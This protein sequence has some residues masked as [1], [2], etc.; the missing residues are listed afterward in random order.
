MND[1]A[2]RIEELRKYNILDTLTEKDY[3]DATF[4]ASV[5]CDAPIALISFV[6]EERQWFKSHR[7]LSVSE[8]LREY[9]FCAHAIA[10]PEEIMI[11]EDSRIDERFKNNPLVT[12]DPKIVFYAGVPLINEEGFGLGTVC[13]ID[14]KVRTLSDDQIKALKALS[15]QVMNLLK[16]RKINFELEKLKLQL[17]TRNKDLEQF[18]MVVSHDI[19]SPLTTILLVNDII[20]QNF[21]DKSG[22]QFNN[23]ISRSNNSANKI[24]SLVDGILAYYQ[25]N[26]S[27]ISPEKIDINAFFESLNNTITS[28][29]KYIITH[30][31]D[32]DVLFFSKVQLEQIFYN[33]VNN[34]IRYNDKEIVQ[35]NIALSEDDNF[36]KFSF[37][38]NGIGIARENHEKI[39][40]LFTT[41]S[42]A[43]N[44]GLRGSGIGLSTIKKIIENAKGSIAVSSELGLGT[45]FKFTIKKIRN[46]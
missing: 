30:T 41:L 19:K 4:L 27:F 25:D 5:I 1:E 20:K 8:T 12:G 6:D 45:T 42:E 18:A 11:V 38:D 39:F 32:I 33:L 22:E 35:I 40:D 3:E 15:T 14:S 34:S 23:L 7:G 26:D 21:T 28:A 44:L 17:E 9:S 37:T 43:D 31:N 29:K 36:Y 16:V 13:I 10:S 46:D 2:G 24:K